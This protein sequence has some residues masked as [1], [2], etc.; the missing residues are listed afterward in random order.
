MEAHSLYL[1]VVSGKLAVCPWLLEVQ[2]KEQVQRGILSTWEH[3]LQVPRYNYINLPR[4]MFP[5]HCYSWC[6]THSWGKAG[7][8][9]KSLTG[10]S[11]F[12]HS[13][14]RNTMNMDFWKKKKPPRKK[15]QRA[16]Y[17]FISHGGAVFHWGCL[18]VYEVT[19][20]SNN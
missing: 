14:M 7:R 1:E 20:I 9:I 2:I 3:E 13:V 17:T 11:W 8:F 12:P 6:M 19:I 15:K 16:T 18:L 5:R 4:I 10:D